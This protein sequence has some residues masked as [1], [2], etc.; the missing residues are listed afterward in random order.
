MPIIWGNI[1]DKDL[2]FPKESFDYILLGDVIEHL[3]NPEETLR[4]LQQFLKRDGYIIASI[5]NILHYSAFIPLP[6][7]EFNYSE[8]GILDRTHL[9]F[10][11]WRSICNMFERLQCE[12]VEVRQNE[13][14]SFMEPWIEGIIS[15]LC[16][17]ST[18]IDRQ[19]FYTW[20]YC[21]K[22]RKR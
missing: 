9:R 8:A 11:T 4:Y 1:E 16:D 22:V 19:G 10:F 17:I 13:M 5:P 6:F 21:M 15:K 3:V 12:I 7:G 18:E 2:N 20:Q 14:D